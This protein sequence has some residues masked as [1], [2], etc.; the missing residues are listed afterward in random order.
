MYRALFRPRCVIQ[1][2]T[3]MT[4]GCALSLFAASDA[5]AR[6]LDPGTYSF[7][8]NATLGSEYFRNTDTLDCADA[9][10]A[11]S[12]ECGA[13]PAGTSLTEFNFSTQAGF[14][15]L[16]LAA[17]RSPLQ[18]LR[19]GPTA[20]SLDIYIGE[21]TET[22]DYLYDF[23][24]DLS[25]TCTIGAISCGD[26]DL[27]DMT[28]VRLFADAN[29]LLQASVDFT[30]WSSLW[31]IDPDAAQIADDDAI[32]GLGDTYD[33]NLVLTDFR[34]TSSPASA[35]NI[36]L[37]AHNLSSVPLPLGALLLPTAFGMLVAL[38]RRKARSAA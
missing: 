25:A 35:G 3:T 34:L 37:Q 11:A 14:D 7:A 19:A 24:T 22:G 26:S 4:M 2:M 9:L 23:D 30:S 21:V 17:V 18:S 33:G 15:A 1:A 20:G 36:S 28:M 32:A 31:S 8:F 13:N 10:A 29:G 12:D 16:D 5:M 38:R 27:S 6:S